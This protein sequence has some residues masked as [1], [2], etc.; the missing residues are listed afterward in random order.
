MS[1]SVH[2]RVERQTVRVDRGVRWRAKRQVDV[3]LQHIG[4]RGFWRRQFRLPPA[5]GQRSPLLENYVLNP[6]NYGKR[7]AAALPPTLTKRLAELQRATPGSEPFLVLRKYYPIGL[8]DWA[9]A[10]NFDDAS[11]TAVRRKLKSTAWYV[12]DSYCDVM[13]TALL[14]ALGAR[15]YSKTPDGQHLY[16]DYFTTPSAIIDQF[17]SDEDLPRRFRQAVPELALVDDPVG[18]EGKLTARF[19]VYACLENPIHDPIWVLPA[20]D[21]IDRLNAAAKAELRNSVFEFFDHWEP[22]LS[23]R[24]V[25]IAQK[26]LG[27]PA[28][29][30]LS[31][32]AN[33]FNWDYE[34]TNPE[35]H[36]AIGELRAHI[37]ELA[38]TAIPV[39]LRRGDAL[40]ID[41]YR[42]LIRRTELQYTPDEPW[43]WG[44]PPVRWVRMY[45]GFPVVRD[46]APPPTKRKRRW[47]FFAAA[48]DEVG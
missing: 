39:Y 8:R 6:H 32:D 9:Y 15:H 17:S 47:G 18:K 27:G 14:S 3:V 40:I 46:D 24:S 12:A 38:A 35:G 30:W 41:N 7:V 45:S 11:F 10:A 33:R 34:F 20:Q 5:P 16:R 22:D 42:A 19:V 23:A 25:T 31:F 2:P 36:R 48:P 13:S 26:V 37:K 4:R 21:V 44:R 29:G 43:L 28:D 1:G